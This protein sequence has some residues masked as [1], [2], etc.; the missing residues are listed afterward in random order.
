MTTIVADLDRCVGAGQCVLTDPD[1]FD[2]SEQDGTVVVLRD[3]PADDE[4]V[5]RARTAVDICPSRALSLTN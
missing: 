4:A 2:Q 5:E 1:A 3:T